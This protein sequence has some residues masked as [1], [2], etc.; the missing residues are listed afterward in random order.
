MTTREKLQ[1]E[2]I[3][4]R[5]ERNS[6]KKELLKV[7]VGEIERLENKNP[8]EEEVIKIIRKMKTNANECGN[9]NEVEILDKYLPQMLS[10]EVI[11]SFVQSI[12]DENNFTLAREMGQIMKIVS[13]SVKANL[14]D[15]KVVSI[16]VKEVLN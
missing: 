16:Y 4:L 5:S 1:L 13:S 9:S 10:K 6:E 11:V 15:K 14:I 2:L 7:V 12:I 3:G 8:T